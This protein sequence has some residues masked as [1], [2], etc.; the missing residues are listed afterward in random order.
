MFAEVDLPVRERR[1]IGGPPVAVEL[2]ACPE[3]LPS[4]FA[5]EA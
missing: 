3:R 1:P 4:P 2:H 5:E